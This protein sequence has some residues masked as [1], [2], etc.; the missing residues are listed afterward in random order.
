MWSCTVYA[1]R[2]DITQGKE[3]LEPG[4]EICITRVHKLF[5]PHLAMFYLFLLGFPDVWSKAFA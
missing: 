4:G 1:W 5:Y 2:K 3:Q